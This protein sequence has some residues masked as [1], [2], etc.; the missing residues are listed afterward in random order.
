MIGTS[1]VLEGNRQEFWKRVESPE[2]EVEDGGGCGKQEA[3]CDSRVK[4][5]LRYTAENGGQSNTHILIFS[6]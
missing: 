5:L 2:K 6:I 3:S 1:G 4:L